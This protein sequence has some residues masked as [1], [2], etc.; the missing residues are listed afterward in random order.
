MD[1]IWTQ[2]ESAFGN[3]LGLLGSFLSA[4]TAGSLVSLLPLLAIGIAIS[5]IMVSVKIVRKVTWGA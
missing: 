4:L 2:V 1:V 5:L 3:M